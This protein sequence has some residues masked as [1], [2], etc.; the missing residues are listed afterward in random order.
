MSAH[1]LYAYTGRPPRSR[2]RAGIADHCIKCGVTKA[3]DG[4]YI[5]QD[6]KY[7]HG[8]LIE[9]QRNIA[10]YAEIDRTCPWPSVVPLCTCET[11]GVTDLSVE[12]SWIYTL[13]PRVEL[14]R[15]DAACGVVEDGR[16][17]DK[18]DP[19]IVIVSAGSTK[20]PFASLKVRATLCRNP[21]CDSASAMEAFAQRHANGAR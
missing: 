14:P 19:R 5:V 16:W 18:K 15:L 10:R 21:R 8:V 1:E 11:C 7:E 2:D 3:V 4:S 9:Q 6:P 12:L 13:V 20:F 17:G